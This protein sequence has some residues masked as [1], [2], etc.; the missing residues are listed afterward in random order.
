MPDASNRHDDVTN[1]RDKPGWIQVVNL[2]MGLVHPYRKHMKSERQM[3]RSACGPTNQRK[4]MTIGQ[5]SHT[6][7]DQA[8][9]DSG[10]E[11]ELYRV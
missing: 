2:E 9:G 1:N 11:V 5:Q 8:D 10:E 4:R 3:K 7:E 6:D